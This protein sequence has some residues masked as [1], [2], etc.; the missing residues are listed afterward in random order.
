MIRPADYRSRLSRPGVARSAKL[1]PSRNPWR[2]SLHRQ[3][4]GGMREGRGLWCNRPSVPA[5]MNRSCQHYTVTLLVPA[6]RMI[7]LVPAHR[8]S[9]VRWSPHLRRSQR[10][11][12]EYKLTESFSTLDPSRQSDWI[13]RSTRKPADSFGGRLLGGRS[14]LFGCGYVVDSRIS[15]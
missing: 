13:R 3:S 7:S 12:E 15:S 11:C 1:S 9:R 8:P 6:R 14:R 4:S 10:Q 5:C 2:R